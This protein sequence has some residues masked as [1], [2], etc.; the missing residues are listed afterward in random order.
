MSSLTSLYA[1]ALILFPIW[2]SI[3]ESEPITNKHLENHGNYE[4][5]QET[6]TVVK[7]TLQVADFNLRSKLYAE[8]R[9]GKL[10]ICQQLL[11]EQLKV[12][13]EAKMQNT[14]LLFLHDTDINTINAKYI[15]PFLYAE[16]LQTARSAIKLYAKLPDA[17]FNKL[18][19]F[20]SAKE[21][22]KATL[23]IRIETWRI[24]AKN[25][26]AAKTLGNEVLA[27][28]NDPEL[29]IQVLALQTACLLENRSAEL[30]NWL[31]AAAK[32]KNPL[33]RLAAAKDPYPE[34]ESRVKELLNDQEA[35]IR[36]AT[37][38]ANH[39]QDLRVLLSCLNDKDEAVQFALVKALQR[40]KVPFTE[41]DLA[42]LMTL[43]QHSSKKVC[44]ELENLFLIAAKQS[45]EAVVKLMLQ[46]LDDNGSTTRLHAIN[47][48]KL[49][50][51]HNAL[52]KI[53]Q[54][55]AQESISENIVAAFEAFIALGEKN[56]YTP[57]LKQFADYKSPLVRASVAKTIGKLQV[58]E[59]ANL[60]LELCIDKPSDLVRIAAFEA[61]GYFPRGIYAKPIL[62]CLKDTRNT[63]SVAR[64][65]AA[66]AAGKL[67][68][69]DSNQEAIL[70]ELANRLLVQCTK[71]V[72][73]DME[74]MFEETSVIANAMYS[75]VNLSKRF[76]Q[77]KD[78]LEYTDMVLR[79][80][81]I[82][83][84]NAHLHFT[85]AQVV[86][87]IDAATNSLANQATAWLNDKE[88]QSTAVPPNNPHFSTNKTK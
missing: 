61:M 62:A 55:T 20:I 83:H 67:I 71:P 23:Q 84:E 15:E 60:L 22:N 4:I 43:F 85:G 65:N 16:D 30:S 82:P 18:K 88:I 38:E 9:E 21:E 72:V 56:N 74:P 37:C 35:A 50:K 42:A 75:L 77:N 47:T 87:L 70:K 24:F 31:D 48:L 86:P 44:N 10:P 29:Q 27:F 81:S 39:N 13:D 73:V 68:P 14:I 76:P 26:L 63:S 19:A 52:P 54:I 58:Q 28:R 59:C 36:V 34:K 78:F 5:T 25:P 46:A 41:D 40:Q 11:L 6:L 3:W 49:L 32:D 2:L 53:S 66:W 45:K 8:L 12:E 51:I 1:T 33:L 7:N 79:I 57:L 80:Y 64:S 17:D 69:E